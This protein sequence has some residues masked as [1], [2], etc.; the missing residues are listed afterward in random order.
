MQLKTT[1]E[2]PDLGELNN[3]HH[4]IIIAIYIPTMLTLILDNLS[5]SEAIYLL[6]NECMSVQYIILYIQLAFC[7]KAA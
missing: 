1:C 7:F 2:V 6:L 3:C 5:T 4:K